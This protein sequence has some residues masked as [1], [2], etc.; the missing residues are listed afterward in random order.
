MKKKA[1]WQSLFFAY[2]EEVY[3]KPFEWGKWDCCMF[4]DACIKTMT[5][6]ALIP[7][8]LKWKDEPSAMKAIK[9]YGGTLGK[10]IDKAAKAQKLKRI[11][12]GFLQ[13]GDLVIWKEETEM[14]GI[15]NGNAILCPSEDG[16]AVKTSE[17]ALRGW[18][19]NG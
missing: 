17:L 15:Y 1:D 5:G 18:R 14:C 9:D 10:A 12:P 11:K 4:S 19:I 16:L 2:I 8:D 3:N 13:S 7:K 6:K